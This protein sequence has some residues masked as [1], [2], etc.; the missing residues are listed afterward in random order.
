MRLG[1]VNAE[2][3]G[4]YDQNQCRF[5]CHNYRLLSIY[6]LPIY[7]ALRLALDP[8]QRLDAIQLT[9]IGLITTIDGTQTNML[10]AA[11]IVLAFAALERRRIRLAALAI[12]GGTLIKLFPAA[13]LAFALP[14]R[15]R[16][17]FGVTFAGMLAVLVALPLTVTSPATLIA[18]YHSWYAMGSVD[19][20]DRGASVMRL[21]HDLFGYAGPNWPV[22]LAGTVLLLLPLVRGRWSDADHR[23]SFLAS[24]LVYSVIFN[25][26]A[27]HPSYIIAVVGIAIWYAVGARTAAKSVLTGAVFVSTVLA[28]IGVAVPQP[29]SNTMLPL[30]LAAAACTLAWLGMQVE[31]LDLVPVPEGTLATPEMQPAE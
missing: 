10:I 6:F 21:L 23:R 25:H 16:W 20:L 14:L 4:E 7:F 11:L 26:K 12:A 13:A 8:S 30:E 22:Q 1:Q 31:L 28:F 27:E 19:A 5:R 17:R 3:L 9:G 15:A 18:Q 24:L 29:L 2:Y